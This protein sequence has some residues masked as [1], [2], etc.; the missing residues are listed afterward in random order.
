M[1]TSVHPEVIE[2]LSSGSDSDDGDTGAVDRCNAG[3]SAVHHSHAEAGVTKASTL[4]GS[5]IGFA[6]AQRFASGKTMDTVS[7]PQAFLRMSCRPVCVS[8]HSW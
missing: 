5:R 2:L 4:A 8:P 7:T 3:Q 6:V 1:A